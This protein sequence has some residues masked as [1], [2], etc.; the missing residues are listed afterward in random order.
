MTYPIEW[1]REHCTDKFEGIPCEY[2][3]CHCSKSNR[4]EME[5]AWNAQLNADFE[6]RRKRI[7]EGSQGETD[8]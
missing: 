2:P 1:I 6:A 5:Q 8:Q 4:D 7:E 3:N